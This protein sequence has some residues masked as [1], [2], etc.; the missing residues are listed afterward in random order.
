MANGL[1]T[2]VCRRW[3]EIGEA[4]VLWSWLRLPTVN[5]ENI[6]VISE[7]L[8]RSKRLQA[9]GTLVARVASEELLLAVTQ[10][11]SLRRLDF[12]HTDLTSIEP[13]VLARAICKM[14]EVDLGRSQFSPE[15]ANIIFQ[16]LSKN[17]N[18]HCLNLFNTNLFAVRPQQLAEAVTQVH[19][20]TLWSCRLTPKHSEAIFRAMTSSCKLRKLDLSYNNLSTVNPNVLA[21]AINRLKSADLGCTCLTGEQASTILSS[22]NCSLLP[23][24]EC[25]LVPDLGVHLLGEPLDQWGEGRGGQGGCGHGSKDCARVK[26]PVARIEK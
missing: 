11:K 16:H 25:H 13:I 17:N 20:V 22:S 4:P 6:D 15:Q 7:L 3:K 23:A 19:Q 10:H 24:G 2:E 18:L 14:E 12:A 9:I 21:A 26:D 1:D 5:Q 8:G